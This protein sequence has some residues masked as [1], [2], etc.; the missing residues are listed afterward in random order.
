M[1]EESVKETVPL[2]IALALKTI[3]A[4]KALSPPCWVWYPG[5]VTP[6]VKSISPVSLS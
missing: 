1:A 2:P 6:P 5:A 3:T 4:I